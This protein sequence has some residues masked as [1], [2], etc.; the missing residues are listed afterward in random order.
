M[1]IMAENTMTISKEDR[2]FWILNILIQHVAPTAV[3]KVFDDKI[4]PHDLANILNSNVKI[5]QDLVKKK[6]IKGHEQDILTRIPG[7]QLPFMPPSPYKT[8][9]AF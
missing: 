8:G 4:P 5:I 1:I 6:V 7:F 3:R 9:K 2:N